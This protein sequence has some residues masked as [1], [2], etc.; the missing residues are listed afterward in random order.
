M[1]E[2]YLLTDDNGKVTAKRIKKNRSGHWAEF[3]RVE[4]W[5]LPIPEIRMAIDVRKVVEMYR[6]KA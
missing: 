4:I 1:P 5:D 3:G 6:E 2:H